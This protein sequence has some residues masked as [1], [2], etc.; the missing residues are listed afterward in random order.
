MNSYNQRVEAFLSKIKDSSDENKCWEWTAAKD[1]DGYG[2]F[3]YINR[4][5]R[6][7]RFSYQHFIGHIPKNKIVCHRCDNPSCVNPNHLWLGTPKQNTADMYKKGR[8]SFSKGKIPTPFKK[9]HGLNHP[10]AKL[11]YEEI[12]SIRNRDGKNLTGASLARKY[13]VSESCIYAI[14]NGTNWKNI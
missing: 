6:A 5:V 3:W 7:A 2:M 1:W 4:N 11:T 14:L 13:K 12:I 8:A 9:H 10:R